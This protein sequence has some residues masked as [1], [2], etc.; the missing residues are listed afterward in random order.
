M[1]DS[2]LKKMLKPSGNHQ[3]ADPAVDGL[4]GVL[5][6]SASVAGLSVLHVQLEAKSRGAQQTDPEKFLA[7]VP[8]S[9]LFFEINCGVEDQIGMMTLDYALFN[10]IDDA[11]TG[12]LDQLSEAPM[13][14]PTSID[15]AICRPYLDELLV[16]FSEILKELRSGK[17]TEIYQTG[18]VEKDPSPHMFPDI[19]YLKLA[20]EFDIANGARQGQMTVLMPARN[21]EF[22]SAAPR[23][24]ESAREWQQAFRATLYGAPATLD[25]VLHR[26]KI[27]L[28]QIMTLNVG[29]VLEIPAKSLETLSIESRKGSARQKLM[30][31]RLGEY[32]EMRA[33]KI[34]HI[35]LTEKSNDGPKM[36]TSE[37][38][39]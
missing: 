26:K 28:R 4:A 30:L 1:A 3:E 21:T 31:A 6:K 16:E 36:L 18:A 23:P 8:E 35:G 24:G 37:P 12:S 14:Q 33:A 9:G 20:I 17:V 32:Q 25:V 19:P 11:L 34:I 39:G 5:G 2:A 22:T 29:D 13:R 10:A 38:V 7:A 27:Q 15:A